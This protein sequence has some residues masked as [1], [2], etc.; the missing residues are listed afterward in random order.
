M[1]NKYEL[2]ITTDGKEV[3]IDMPFL[4][5]SNIVNELPDVKE[6]EVIFNA[7]TNHPSKQVLTNLAVKT[8]LSAESLIKLFNT[9]Y[10]SV[11]QSLLSNSIFKKG[12]GMEG[13]ELM[14]KVDAEFANTIAQSIEEFE[15]VDKMK[16]VELL[17]TNKNPRVIHTT[18]NNSN[19]K[20]NMIKKFKDYP[21]NL[22]AMDTIKKLETEEENNG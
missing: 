6:N 13:L 14:I 22:I 4:N 8:S 12:I 10:N 18:I 2:V 17:L 9:G 15:E 5:V 3:R 19:T 1:A 16:L 20:K 11:I 21:D 7:L